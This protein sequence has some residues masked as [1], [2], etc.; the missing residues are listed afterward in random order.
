MERPRLIRHVEASVA[1][2]E[3][4]A[5]S[6]HSLD[7]NEAVQILGAHPVGIAP[8]RRIDPNLVPRPQRIELRPHLTPD[9][10]V[11]ERDDVRVRHGLADRRDRAEK[12]LPLA[13]ALARTPS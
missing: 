13:P 3:A 8:V 6:P 10:S 5:R 11:L 7:L 1:R 4:P 12:L 2:C 9:L